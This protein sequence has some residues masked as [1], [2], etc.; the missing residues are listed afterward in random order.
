MLCCYLYLYLDRQLRLFQRGSLCVR[1]TLS[2]QGHI[3]PRGTETPLVHTHTYNQPKHFNYDD[4]MRCNP[5][6]TAAQK[7]NKKKVLLYVVKQTWTEEYL[8][9]NSHYLIL[10]I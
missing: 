7:Q 1:H 4:I 2:L 10:K 5:S 9:N 6:V 8:Q 3:C